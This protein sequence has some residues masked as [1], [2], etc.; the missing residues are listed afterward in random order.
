[1]ISAMPRLVSVWPSWTLPS[2]CTKVLCMCCRGTQSAMLCCQECKTVRQAGFSCPYLQVAACLQGVWWDESSLLMLPHMDRAALQSLASRKLEALP[3]L[4][5]EA[6]R[7][8]ARAQQLLE[9][10]LGSAK[11]AQE[12]LQASSSP[13]HS[14]QAILRPTMN[15]LG[16]LPISFAEA[17][18]L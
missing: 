15:T 2:C 6:R 12:C 7:Q 4:L 1:M 5:I 9:Q 17:A 11:R 3:Q 14:A 10:A 16:L 8:P 13:N 18:V